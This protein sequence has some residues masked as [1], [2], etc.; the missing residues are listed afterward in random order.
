[1]NQDTSSLSDYDLQRYSRQMML[2]GWGEA[3]QQKIKNSSVFIAGAGGLGSPVALFLAAA[4]LGEIR[5]CDD[6]SVDLSNLN[7]QILH[8]DSRIGQLKARSAEQTLLEINPGITINAFAERLDETNTERIIGQPDIVVD[9]LD[10]YPTRYLLNE[11][12][13]TQRIPLVH[14]AIW[15]LI[16]QIT[17]IQTPETPCLKCLIPEAPPKEV[18]PVLGA[19]PG[20]IGSLQAMETL[21]YLTGI[22]ECLKGRL[23]IFDG[24][25]M[26]FETI[27]VKRRPGCSVCGVDQAGNH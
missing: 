15:G 19:T 3:G 24:D 23:L 11:Y 18:F 26:S 20:V 13:V 1:M 14:A 6:D 4:G 7:R 10:N 9:C 5:I 27:K 12:C 2:A 21:K 16:G 17:F 25:N 8:S 22:G